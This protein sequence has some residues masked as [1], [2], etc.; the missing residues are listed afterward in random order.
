MKTRLPT[1]QEI[2]ELVAFLPRLYAEGFKPVKEW[3]GGTKEKDGSITM[4]WPEYN[5]VVEDFFRIA[6]SEWWRDY[7]YLSVE[8]GRML[9]NQEVVK[10][11]SLS[12]IKSMLT[13]CVRGERFCYGHWVA[14]IEHGYIRRLLERLAELGS[15]NAQLGGSADGEPHGQE[16]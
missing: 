11:A 8:A 4:P 6:A 9:E 12:Q 15:K 14:M 5:R 7:N 2:E 10:I 1:S 3:R 16:Y 13:Y